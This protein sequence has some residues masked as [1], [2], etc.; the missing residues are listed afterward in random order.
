VVISPP[1]SPRPVAARGLDVKELKLVINY[2]APNHMED[3]VHR[4]GR[5]GRAGNTGTCITFVTPEQEKFSVDIVR[6]LEA[7][8]AFIPD[9]LKEMSDGFLKKIKSGKARAA[10]SGF[11]GK[12]LDR[13]ERKREEKDRAEKHTYGDTSEAV[14]LSS[15]EVQSSRTSPSRTT[16]SLARTP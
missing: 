9:K 15:R 14:S 12:G 1:W 11:A 10:G 8:N 2:D 7:S 4:A 13:I 6:A 16:S 3:Y 5:T